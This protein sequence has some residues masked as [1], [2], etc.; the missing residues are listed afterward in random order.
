MKINSTGALDDCFFQ[1]RLSFLKVLT[2]TGEGADKI[3][4]APMCRHAA[5]RTLNRESVDMAVE[6]AGAVG[7]D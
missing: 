3:H 1:F 4:N 7:P 2:L 5:L 6:V